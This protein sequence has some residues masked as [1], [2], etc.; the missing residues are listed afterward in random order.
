VTDH[1]AT[2]DEHALEI[3]RRII[4]NLNY[5]KAPSVTMRPPVEPLYDINEIYGIIPKDSKQQFDIREVC[6]WN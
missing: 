3:T 6:H 2:C 1:F 5:R 4:D